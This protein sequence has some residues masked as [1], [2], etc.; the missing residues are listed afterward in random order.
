MAG[1]LAPQRWL[2]GPADL[3]RVLAAWGEPASRQ[4]PGQVGRQPGYGVKALGLVLVE[5]WDRGEEC[6]GVGMVD[7]LEEAI[8]RSRLDHLACVHHH[9]AVGVAGNDPHIV[10]DQ[11]D[12]H[13]E[14]L[15]QVVEQGQD[16]RLDRDIESGGRLVGDQQFRLAG[17]RHGDHD[18]LAQAARKLVRV[19][20]QTLRGVRHAHQAEHFARPFECLF[21]GDLLVKDDAFGYLTPDVHRGVERGQ[22][23]LK[24]HPDLVAPH[25]ADLF[26]GHGGELLV[27]QADR[28]SDDVAAVGQ[29]AH[30]RV[31]HHRLATARLPHHAQ[32]LAR[33]H[34]QGH[35]VDRFD[36]AGAQLYLSTEVLY[37][38]QAHRGIALVNAPG[39]VLRSCRAGH[40]R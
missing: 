8:G 28:A 9:R 20:T 33:L 18:A 32:R 6:F 12:C 16:L 15:L 19:V 34:A 14:V 36:Y 30:Y 22:R 26:V 4:R 35:A 1:V 7:V 37:F 40:R 5:L 11:Q 24:D 23:V 27:G 21:L 38:Q 25:G 10:G 3:R 31:G 13:T 2:L 29:E 39:A 17:E